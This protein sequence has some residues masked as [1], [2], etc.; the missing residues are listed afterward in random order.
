ML[1]F[2]FAP[3]HPTFSDQ[4]NIVRVNYGYWDRQ[5]ANAS[6]KLSSNNYDSGEWT[7]SKPQPILTA[8]ANLQVWIEVYNATPIFNYS[9][10]L[11]MTSWLYIHFREHLTFFGIMKLNA[12]GSLVCGINS[13]IV[14][15]GVG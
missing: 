11:T 4:M 13:C 3:T 8:Q 9:C 2:D 12:V 1:A 15:A 7:I 10:I 14:F 6:E 5:E